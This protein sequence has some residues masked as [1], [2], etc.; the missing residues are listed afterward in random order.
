R[1]AEAAAERGD[2]IRQLL[3]LQHPGERRA[4]RVQHL[5]AQR[6]DRL[7]RAVASLLGAAARRIPLD[8]EELGVLAAG[9]GAVTEL[10]GQRQ[11]RGRPAL[12]GDLLLRRAARF[13]RPR[14]EDD[15]RDDR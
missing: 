13:A 7:P 11:A 14:R 3:V 9:V 10:A 15:A 2:E 4:L 12:A 5:P 1:L 6:Q 8:D